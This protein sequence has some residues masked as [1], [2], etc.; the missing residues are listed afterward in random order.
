MPFDWSFEDRMTAVCSKNCGNIVCSTTAEQIL[1]DGRRRKIVAMASTG[2]A[3]SFAINLRTAVPPLVVLIVRAAVL[4]AP[5]S[6]AVR[7]FL[8]VPVGFGHDAHALQHFGLVM[9]AALLLN[10]HAMH[11]V[12]ASVRS[13]AGACLL[14]LFE[15][16]ALSFRSRFATR[17]GQ[18]WQNGDADL[19]D[20]PMKKREKISMHH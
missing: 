6:P 15:R 18:D 20:V 3:T 19:K 8:P 16:Y 10:Q 7:R 9:V 2:T 4:F 11:M 17:Q 14:V 13:E 1:R 12:R 5:P